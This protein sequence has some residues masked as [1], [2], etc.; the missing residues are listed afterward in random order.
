MDFNW[1][2]LGMTVGDCKSLAAAL[3]QNST[4]KNLIIR[5]SYIDDTRVRIIAAG[6]LE[7]KAL[8]RLGKS[9]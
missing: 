3:K 2:N 5:S 9:F 1:K 8:Q 4:L 7:T 6:L